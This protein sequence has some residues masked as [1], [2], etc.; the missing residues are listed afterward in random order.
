VSDE[1]Q[2]GLGGSGVFKVIV[3]SARAVKRALS[4][5]DHSLTPEMSDVGSQIGRCFVA[6]RFADVHA[7][8]A[9]IMQSTSDVDRFVTRW[10]DAVKDKGPFTSFEISNAGDIDLAFVP[11]L[12]EIP[13]EQFAGF[14]EISFSNATEE[15]AFTVGA[16]LIEDAGGGRVRIGA[17]HAR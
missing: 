1:R 13:Q 4:E 16:V 7:M 9:P 10:H 11:S 5:A 12:E 15:D 3:D 6:N 17:L 14:L 8:A 2:P